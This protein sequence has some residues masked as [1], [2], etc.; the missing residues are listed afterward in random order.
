MTHFS[1][2][3]LGWSAH[4]ASQAKGKP[5][6]PARVC[7]VARDRIEALTPNGTVALTLPGK[8]STGTVAVGDWVLHDP[9]TL[10]SLEVLERRT[11]L[12]RRAAGAPATPQAIAANV[13]TLG[14]VS[15]CNHD[16]NVAR[17][18]R[19]LALADASGCL[20]LVV[21]TR[22]DEADD[23]ANYRRRAEAISPLVVALT[24]DARDPAQVARLAS[25]AD[26]GQTLALVGSSGVGKTT[27]SNALTGRQDGTR[28]IREDD[29]RGRHTTTARALHR[30]TGGGWL[31][32]TP[33][34][35]ELGL[36][37][38]ADGIETVFADLSDLAAR[39]RFTDCRHETEPGCAIRA[40][41]AA[42]RLDPDRLARWRKLRREDARNAETLAEAHARDRSFGRLVRQGK[43]R[44][45]H[46]RGD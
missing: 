25:R 7:A 44:G 28:G 32:D 3:D 23:A 11:L 21:L 30:T 40:E 24:L 36:T 2:A 18:E 33:G 22:A 42:G 38:A 17:L 46:K 13:D 37:G 31:V 41:I 20:P 27:L 34:M 45:R 4:F 16:F 39:C 6:A 9:A 8:R 26:R 10:R 12:Q 29:S 43:A 14:I 5:G 35:R 15:A 19:Y 1:L